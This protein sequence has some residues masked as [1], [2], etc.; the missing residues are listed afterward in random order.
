VEGHTS[1]IFEGDKKMPR[2]KSELTKSGKCI[3][4]RLSQKHYELWVKAGATKWLREQ[5]EKID[6]K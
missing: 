3:G 6:K 2:P 4:V 1:R 5:L